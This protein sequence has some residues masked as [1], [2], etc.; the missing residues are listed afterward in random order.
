MTR[1]GVTWYYQPYEIGPYYLG[2]ISVSLSW[3]DL[4]E[5]IRK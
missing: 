4:K 5:Y 2:V 1:K 3:E